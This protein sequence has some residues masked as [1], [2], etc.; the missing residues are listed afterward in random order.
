LV[1]VTHTYNAVVNTLFGCIKIKLL[2][3]IVLFKIVI[4]VNGYSD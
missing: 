4:I 2:Y 3:R 1:L